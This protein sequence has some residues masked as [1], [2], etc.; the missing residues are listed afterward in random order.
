MLKNKKKKSKFLYLVGIL[1]FLQSCTISSVSL[2]LER[3]KEAES[4]RDFKKAA[5][6]YLRAIKR[7]PKKGEAIYS[8][9]KLANLALIKLK[10]YNKANYAYRF[11]IQNSHKEEDRLLAQEN[12]ALLYFE[13]L[14]KYPEAILELSRFIDLSTD[15]AK[16]LKAKLMIA[17]SYFYQNKFYQAE[18]EVDEIL[19]E[20]KDSHT[21]FR[22]GL[23]KASI[24]HSKKKIKEAVEI[25]KDLLVQ[26]MELSISEKIPISIAV[27]YEDLKM[28]DEAL[29]I[30]SEY[31]ERLEDIQ[32]VDLKMNR[33]KET[34]LL[35]PGA[36]GLRK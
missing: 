4:N 7:S 2:E 24:L 16:K 28:F 30:L 21:K 5:Q 17:R 33:I 34:M 8:A 35:Q 10:D 3:A 26:H 20:S 32:Y 15:E 27:C 23:L 19:E 13:K 36:K 25:Y 14:S 9:K 18:I 6:H 22:A 29:N 1:F 31:R 11:L 12:L